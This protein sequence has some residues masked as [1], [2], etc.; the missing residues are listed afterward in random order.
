MVSWYPAN[1]LSDA[2]SWPPMSNK[3]WWGLQKEVELKDGVSVGKTDRVCMD[4]IALY[5]VNVILYSVDTAFSTSSSRLMG[6]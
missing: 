6:S 3:M 1:V 2:D 4:N 5:A